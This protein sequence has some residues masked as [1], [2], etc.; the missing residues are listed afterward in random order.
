ML[1]NP[2]PLPKLENIRLTFRHGRKQLQVT[3]REGKPSGV[4]RGKLPNPHGPFGIASQRAQLP[5]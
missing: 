4:H 1:S 3:P 2:V 5:R